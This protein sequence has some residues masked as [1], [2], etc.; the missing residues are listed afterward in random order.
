MDHD[1]DLVTT[2]IAARDLG[3]TRTTLGRWAAAG[4][5]TPARRTAGGHLR[6]DLPTLR[7]QVK[8]LQKGESDDRNHHE[9][10]TTATTGGTPRP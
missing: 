5:V 6:W 8:A 10:E 3:V 2:G 1:L 4:L 9:S 7:Q